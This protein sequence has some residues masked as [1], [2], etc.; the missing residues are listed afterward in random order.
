MIQTIDEKLDAVLEPQGF[1]PDDLQLADVPA[2][3][4]H[5]A[6][7]IVPFGMVLLFAFWCVTSMAFVL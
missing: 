4:W 7:R 6:T 5:I 3:L 1:D 2:A